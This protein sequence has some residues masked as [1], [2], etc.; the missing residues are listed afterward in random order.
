[1]SDMTTHGTKTEITET[2]DELLRVFSRFGESEIN[3]VPSEG[4]WTAGQVAEHILKS[5]RGLPKLFAG[6]TEPAS[7][8]VD[9]KI[10]D[11]RAMFL[12]MELKMQ[13]PEFNRPSAGPHDKNRLS[14]AIQKL[15]TELEQCAGTDAPDLLYTDFAMPVFGHLSRREWLAFV[16]AHTQRHTLQMQNIE[17][18]LNL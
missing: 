4:S 13:A 18:R 15:K 6:K 17:K 3:R 5:G 7:R 12:N 14:E 11:I 9:E 10:P 8:P 16:A 1:M 2:F